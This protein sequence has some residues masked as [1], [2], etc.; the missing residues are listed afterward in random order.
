MSTLLFNE[1]N[2]EQNKEKNTKTKLTPNKH[3]NQKQKERERKRTHINK[4][5]TNRHSNSKQNPNF[6]ENKFD[7]ASEDWIDLLTLNPS[8]FLNY[9][10]LSTEFE[11]VST[12]EEFFEESDPNGTFP[13][14]SESTWPLGFENEWF[15]FF[16][17]GIPKKRRSTF[18]NDSKD[19]T[20]L[21]KSESL[22]NVMSR[23]RTNLSFENENSQNENKQLSTNK[24]KS[25]TQTKHN[26]NRNQD[27]NKEMKTQRKPKAK[28]NLNNFN[29]HLEED[30]KED[31][32]TIDEDDFEFFN[33]FRNK[34][35]KRNSKKQLSG[36]RILR[37]GSRSSMNLT[38]LVSFNFEDHLNDD[39]DMESDNVMNKDNDRNND[40]NN[41][42]IGSNNNSS[43][44]N[45]NNKRNSRNRNRNSR[46]SRN[47]NRN[48]STSRVVNNNAY[49]GNDNSDEIIKDQLLKLQVLLGNKYNGLGESNNNLGL[50]QNLSPKNLG[51]KKPNQL[52]VSSHSRSI[53]TQLEGYAIEHFSPSRGKRILRRKEAPIK[54]K[55]KLTYS[56]HKIQ[57]SITRLTKAK[58]NR[59]AIETFKKLLFYMGEPKAV[60]KFEKRNKR[61][62]VKKTIRELAQNEIIKSILEI[63][64]NNAELRDEIYVQI[65]KQTTRN[66]NPHSNLRGWGAMCLVTQTFPPSN[67]LIDYL[68]KLFNY[69]IKNS[70]DHILEFA[71]Y[72]KRKLNLIILKKSGFKL[73]SDRM[74]KRIFAVP[75]D[76]IVFNTTLEKCMIAQKKLHPNE[77]IPHVLTFLIEKIKNSKNFLKEGLFRV[78]GNAKKINELKELLNSGVFE[79][80]DPEIDNAFNYASTLKSWLRDLTEPLVPF[81]LVD[82]ILN[83]DKEAQMIDIVQKIPQ[84]QKYTLAYLI[85]FIKDL[86]DPKI[87]KKTKM[88]KQSLVLMFAPNII[89]VKKQTLNIVVQIN[90]KRNLFLTSL[91]NEWQIDEIINKILIS[92]KKSEK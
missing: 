75:Y 11:R 12:L 34:P 9:T 79:I 51:I 49:E 21:S 65:S 53:S 57:S 83:S 15:P 37:T 72:C 84:L 39:N 77:I 6:Q 2:N 26:P 18:S 8:T 69:Y 5:P 17:K 30:E 67:D 78:P 74:I 35:K 50:K 88:D 19:F 46:N 92:L 87:V 16:D 89:R 61:L 54:L 60:K 47:R 76:P 23:P 82:S 59:L 3:H 71:Q 73:P 48:N 31:L 66:P 13:N 64:I 4:T 70:K 85:L 55:R 22:K 36:I 33:N 86:I 62:R 90:A 20:R 27:Q 80:E 10:P 14:E 81:S 1:T 68:K 45:N 28:K 91:L 58:H 42:I 63:G 52:T 29:F 44:R 38:E 24:N 56:S 32:K 25:Q 7:S 40:D 41:N 43:R